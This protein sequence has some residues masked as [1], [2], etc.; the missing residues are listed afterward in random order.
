[1]TRLPQTLLINPTI[2]S[3]S[4][5]RFPLSLL[6]LAAA[7]DQSGNS[8][9]ID[10][11]VDRDVIGATMHAME[12]NAFDAVG[13][14]VMGGPQIAPSIEVSKA[15]RERYPAIP[16]IWGG[17]FPTLYTD[18]A[19]V[20]P[21]VDY[22]IRGQAEE[23]LPELIAALTGPAVPD[24]AKIGSLSWKH[25]GAVV[26]NPNRRFT[27][28]DSGLVLP[29]D[30]LG[31]PRRYLARTF[32]GRR[33]V[34]HQAAIG[35]R[36]RCTFCGVAAMFGG[37]T[38]L[39]AVARLE[40]D[41]RYLKYELGADSVQ[42][43]DHNFFDREQDMI[44]LLEVMAKLEMPWWCYARSDALL[45][46]SESTWK[47]VRKS[48]LRMAYIGAESPSGQMLKEIRKG[49]RPDQTLEVAEL[50]RRNGVIPEMSFMVAPPENT[51]EE[52]ELTFEFIR[53][54]KR[55]NPESEIIV[56]IYTPLPESS[57]H[58]KDRNKRPGMA[59]L[60][61]NGEPV[62]FP[63]TPEEWME[64]R[65]VDYAC[66][67]DA[68]WLTDKLRRRILDFVTVLRC[69]FPTVQDLRSPPWTKRSLSAMASWRYRQRRYDRPWELNLAN[70]L[71]RLRMPQVS[72]L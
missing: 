12:Q 11:N 13:I 68:P 31:D 62:V 32:L 1:M 57:K 28:G 25:D 43:F 27:L 66:H 35:C 21:Y 47:L 64:P 5:A 34:A 55:I 61:L 39:P 59:L 14:S 3:R 22:A 58:E 29:Y 17:Y 9:I 37:T 2:T 26:H 63:K 70:R 41:L 10:G 18:T 20:A 7:L 8:T 65:W 53:D 23:S 49:T 44:P 45:G 67:A 42:F 36:F 46:L 33:T 38:V 16:I 52:T 51:E 6:H 69:R 4:S 71:V 60:D 54:L 19:L 24:L 50:C 40:R 15:I 48:R 56:Y 30:K 72:G